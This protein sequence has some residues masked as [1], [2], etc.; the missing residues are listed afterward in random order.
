MDEEAWALFASDGEDEESAPPD[1]RVVPG[2]V[3]AAVTSQQAVEKPAWE[4]LLPR[5]TEEPRPLEQSG[6]KAAVAPFSSPPIYQAAC[7]M[8]RASMA[9][10][11]GG[12]GFVAG[13][14]ILPGTLLIAERR[15]LPM[16]RPED[17]GAAGGISQEELCLRWM[18][19]L[20]APNIKAAMQ[21]LALL[22]PVSLDDVSP[23][24]K[25]SLVSN[26]MEAVEDMISQVSPDV[27]KDLNLSTMEL[28][29]IL[30]AF[31]SN[32]FSSGVYLHVAMTNHS[33]RP[34][35]VKWQ[36]EDGKEGLS[37][38]RAT[39]LIRKG[40]EITIS[41][42]EPRELSLAT[43]KQRLQDQFGFSCSCPLC[44]GSPSTS[45]LEAFNGFGG[46]TGPSPVEG[47][48]RRGRRV[49]K[50]I[51][52]RG[53]GHQ[54]GDKGK[55]KDKEEDKDKDKGKEETHDGCAADDEYDV[56]AM[57]ILEERL[58]AV[59]SIVSLAVDSEV[60]WDGLLC[61]LISFRTQAETLLAPR[62]MALARVNKQVASA[63][64]TLLEG[65]LEAAEGN[66]EC[67]NA[68]HEA[69]LREG[70]QI[71]M[72]LGTAEGS[73]GEGCVE[74]ASN[75]TS[76]GERRAAGQVAS[77][78]TLLLLVFLSSLLSLRQ[79]Q[80]FY[81]GDAPHPEAA[82]C[83]ADISQAI[84]M[85]LAQG[86]EGRRCITSLRKD[87]QEEGRRDPVPTSQCR[88]GGGAWF[89]GLGSASRFERECDKAARKIGRLFASTL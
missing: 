34:N 9:H 37:E 39:E 71:A 64:A 3:P 70:L 4:V 8:F 24:R 76:T 1:A 67:R 21:D 16:P 23:V 45:P 42:L 50:G 51:G 44:D 58:D 84:G 53:G 30:C 48:R 52:D 74:A 57:D 6:R 7:M 85:L 65:S 10:R 2:Y 87:L 29:R 77:F 28:L 27:A 69:L 75:C 33:C 22:Y 63:C 55:G 59:E 18:L 60:R 68:V 56:V 35:A 26:Y 79:T 20:P 82:A 25:E 73:G 14:D 54:S 40:E 17:C 66:G 88:R 32:A 36:G 72:C 83:L 89:G 12:R 86:P 43:R 19:D 78:R 49:G 81:L 61:E 11:G 62:H 13:E 15:L 5:F 47:E 38:V 31:Q 41:Y 80:V 46:A